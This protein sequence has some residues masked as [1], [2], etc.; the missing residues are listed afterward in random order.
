MVDDGIGIVPPQGHARVFQHLAGR[1]PG[2]VNEFFGHR[3]Q[4]R[5]PF[6][7]VGTVWIELGTLRHRTEDTE[8][9]GGIRTAP[10][11]PL[12]A[13]RVVSEVGI[14]EGVPKPGVRTSQ[15]TSFK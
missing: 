10:G 13:C 11:D 3:A 7:Y 1:G 4:F 15:R 14:D 9:G 5:H 6:S 2:F 12:P 8:I